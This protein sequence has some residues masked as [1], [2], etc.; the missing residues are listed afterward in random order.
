MTGME[1]FFLVCAGIGGVLFLVRL[2]M[3]LFGSDHADA[4]VSAGHEF[5][6]H[7]V[8]AGFKLLSVQGVTAFFLMFG[9]V[10]YAMLHASKLSS[11]WA[12]AGATGSGAVAMVL[13]AWIFM[14]ARKLQS[15][16]TLDLA[17]AVGQEG[18]IYLRIPPGGTG[19]AQVTLQG[20]LVI[21]D[22]NSEGKEEIKTGDR[23]RVVR[24]VSDSI[25]TVQKL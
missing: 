9:L 21:L 6:V 15:S 24:V 14:M 3:M 10:G 18:L 5:A 13:I 2:A 8:D 7:E 20:R 16:G 23:V 1:T 4:D 17:N 19:K 25:I 11:G 22:A 12:V